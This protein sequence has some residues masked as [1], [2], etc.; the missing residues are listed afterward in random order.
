[1]KTLNGSV[2]TAIVFSQEPQHPIL[3]VAAQYEFNWNDHM[4]EPAELIIGY[5]MTSLHLFFFS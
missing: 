1:M 4:R 2:I 3:Y 5:I